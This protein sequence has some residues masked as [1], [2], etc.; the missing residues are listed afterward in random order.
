MFSMIKPTLGETRSYIFSQGGLLWPVGLAT[1]GLGQALATLAIGQFLKTGGWT[2]PG[3]VALFG[4]LLWSQLGYLTISG[5]VIGGNDSVGQHFGKA[6]AK[7]PLV[8]LIFI[9]SILVMSIL[10]IPFVIAAQM[11]GVSIIQQTAAG[12]QVSPFLTTPMLIIMFIMFAKLYLGWAGLMDGRF[13]AL[14]GVI[15][16]LALTRGRL[17]FFVSI[18]LF[19]SF[20]FQIM[21]SIGNVVGVVLASSLAAILDSESGLN[22]LVALTAGGFATIPMVI[23]SVFSA[24]LYMKLSQER[25]VRR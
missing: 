11:N 1:F 20:A 8:I 18:A 2:V 22:A 16:C 17:F 13:S 21:Q 3:V 10:L 5:M 6:F 19:F 14:K 7:L 23:A 15:F 4:G 24:L 9:V 25:D 12:P